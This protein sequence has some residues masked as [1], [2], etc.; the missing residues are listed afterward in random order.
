MAP[1]P[2]PAHQ[3][4]RA[5]LPHPAF[6]LAS[7]QGPRR[8]V[9]KAGVGRQHPDRGSLR[10][11]AKLPP[12]PSELNGAD[13]HEASH[14]SLASS[15]AHQ[16]SG[17]F[18]PTALPGINALTALSDFRRDR[19]P[20][21]TL[22]PLPSSRT[23]L[24]RLPE[25]PCVRAVPT[26]PADR[27][28]C[29]CRLLPRLTRPSPNSGRVGIRIVLFEACSGF[30]RVTAR[31]LAQPPKAAFVTGLRRGRLPG[32]AARQLPAQST[33]RWVEPT[34]TGVS[35]LRGAPEVADM[36]ATWKLS[37]QRTLVPY[38]YAPKSRH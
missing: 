24:P 23:D 22:R 30:T 21:S 16:K 5:D 15:K 19:R 38:C 37:P 7:P 26:T 32:H 12:T 3:T 13:R 36:V 10:P 1:F 14:R 28:G 20:K 18:A 9:L 31:T 4:G 2:L 25:P 35:R 11:A 8:T 34:S 33:T 29:T 17:P 6:R 27:N